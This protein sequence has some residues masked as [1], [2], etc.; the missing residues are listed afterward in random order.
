MYAL[1]IVPSCEESIRKKC[2]KNR[3]LQEAVGSKVAQIL[4][5]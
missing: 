2:R 4:G 5:T 3:P 1:E